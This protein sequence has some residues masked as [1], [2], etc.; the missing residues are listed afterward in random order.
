MTEQVTVSQLISPR[1]LKDQPV[2]PLLY[3]SSENAGWRGLVAQ[4]FREPMELEGWISP[5]MSDISLILFAGGSMRMEQRHTN[6]RWREVYMHQGNLL[7]RPGTGM[8]Y[9]VR[10]QS[11]AAAPAQTLHLHL[12]KDLLACTAEEV[13]GYDPAYLTL[14][15]RFGFQDPLLTQIGFALWRELEECSPAG[16]LYAETATQMLA[17]HL[18]RHYTSAGDVI[19][20]PLQKLTH[21]QVRRVTDFVQAHLGQDLSLDVLAQQTG[22][23]PYHFARLFRQTTGESPH[24]F[25]LHQRIEKALH[26]LKKKD[27]SL[28]YVALE[29]GF[30][31]QSHLTKVF[32]RHL[33]L[34]PG[35]YRR[36]NS[37]RADL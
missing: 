33:G 17:V 28:A 9:E 7:L 21:Q 1:A 6:G 4:A 29:S 10:W 19:K 26:L 22:F 12:S 35:A 30:A 31:N 3:L 13:A 2:S 20:E 27:V 34:T 15:E 18:L 8:S 14:M 16:R 24:Q 25:V 5:A 11:L 37:I 32:K 23:S 36:D